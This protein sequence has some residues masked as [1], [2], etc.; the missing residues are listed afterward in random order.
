MSKVIDEIR[1]KKGRCRKSI[2]KMELSSAE[3]EGQ[4]NLPLNFIGNE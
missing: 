2:A 3:T 4:G 1:V